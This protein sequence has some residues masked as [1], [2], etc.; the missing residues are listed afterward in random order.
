M[1]SRRTFV[2]T[3]AAAAGALAASP[4]DTFASPTH[5]D[6]TLFQQVPP[7]IA[8][9][10]SWADRATPITKEE[11]ATRVEKAKRLMRGHDMDA[12]FLTGGTS[13]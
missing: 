8:R 6:P 5:G 9:L 1:I 11:R 3:G 10:K 12:L 7:S 2:S 13:M 4:K